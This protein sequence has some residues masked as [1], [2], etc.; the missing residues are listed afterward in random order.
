MI[1]RLA[2]ACLFGFAVGAI[3]PAL[4]EARR[5]PDPPPVQLYRIA[6]IATPF[7][8]YVSAIAHDGRAIFHTCRGLIIRV[9]VAD[10]VPERGQD[11]R[12]LHD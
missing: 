12:A 10:L 2:A 1:A 11:C 4:T 8:G 3:L 6:D 9:P 5:A 7:K